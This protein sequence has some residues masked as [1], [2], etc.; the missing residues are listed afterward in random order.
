MNASRLFLTYEPYLLP[1]VLANLVSVHTKQ[2]AQ[3]T[4]QTAGLLL[5]QVGLQLSFETLTTHT[6]MDTVQPF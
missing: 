1:G 6:Q 3:V 5:R 4:R 2:D